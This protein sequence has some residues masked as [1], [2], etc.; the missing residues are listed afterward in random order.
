MHMRDTGYY[1]RVMSYP[2]KNFYIR[3]Q[4]AGG[5]ALEV[6]CITQISDYVVSMHTLFLQ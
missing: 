1:Y 4:H 3:C 2:K 5:P 6:S